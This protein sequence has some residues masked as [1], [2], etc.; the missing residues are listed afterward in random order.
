MPSLPGGP[1]VPTLPP[2]TP[3]APDL[4][5]TLNRTMHAVNNALRDPV[6]RPPDDAHALARDLNGARV[7]RG[8]ALAM[9]P[10][11]DS[12]AVARRLGFTLVRQ[13]RL[14]P[15]GL[16]VAV[17]R[18]PDGMRVSEALA[19]LRKADPA[20]TYDYN[21]IYDPGGGLDAGAPGTRTPQGAAGVT[22]I[23]MIDAGIDRQHPALAQVR[24]E[25]KDFAAD[26]PGPATAH[27]TAVASLLVGQ[28]DDFHGALRGAALY[29]ADVYG[30]QASGGNAE[31][32]A[33]ALAWLAAAEIPV[34]NISLSGPPN[35]LLA[36]ATAAF[37]ARG[38]V[39][40]AAVGNDGPAGSVRYP[41]AYPGV[42]GATSVDAQLRIQIDAN[43]GPDVAFAARGVD[44]RAATS[45]GGYHDVT[46]TSFA[47]PIVAARFAVLMTGAD[48]AAAVRAWA[49]L[50]HAAV[51]LGV[52]GRDPIF[53]YGY[54]DSPTAAA[55]VDQPGSTK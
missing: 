27:G 41:A 43:R 30:G 12:L 18:V 50:K 33:R 28:D 21:H 10:T 32:I 37:I 51:D 15:L 31:D 22:R 4:G 5:G 53:G 24:I 26:R 16:S 46:G 1:I 54:L 6:G 11:E 38:H 14:Q 52:S 49:A 2:A 44:V 42:A 36:A 3:A 34:T 35:A 29:A 45:G 20:G 39:L 47:A 13:D 40:V 8:E 48:S 17:L 9:A 55:A 25:T 19:V 7:V 23:G